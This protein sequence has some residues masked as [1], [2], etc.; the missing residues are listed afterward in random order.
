MTSDPIPNATS[1]PGLRDGLLRFG[2]QDGPTTS[3][4]GPDRALANLSARRAKA[5][6]LLT[7]GTYGQHSTT[8]SLSAGLRSS[9]GSRLQALTASLGSTLFRLTWKERVTPAGRSISALRASAPRTSGRDFTGWPTPVASDDNK[10][11]EAHLAMKRRMGER[12]GTGANRTSIT[13]LSV[14]V[15]L[16]GWPTPCS[17]DGPNGGPAQGGD[18]LPGAVPLAHWISPLTREWKVGNQECRDRPQGVTMPEQVQLAKGEAARLT[19]SGEL[20]TG[21][22]A[23]MESGGALS[24]EHSRWLMG[25]PPEWESCAPMAMPSSRRK[26][27]HSSEPT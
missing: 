27:K 26:P 19:V 24:P 9:L 16:A 20:L 7:S 5:E 21:S 3:P 6:G 15:K 4:S 11:V 10:S 12:D 25:F 22:T 2:E 18:R 13:S 17:Q 1:S 14:L 23:G 8:S